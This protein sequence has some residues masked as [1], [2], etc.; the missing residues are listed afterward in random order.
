VINFQLEE[1]VYP[2]VCRYALAQLLLA[3]WSSPDCATE[4]LIKGIWNKHDR[5]SWKGCTHFPYVCGERE[6]AVFCVASIKRM[7]LDSFLKIYFSSTDDDSLVPKLQKIKPS[8]PVLICSSFKEK[9]LSKHDTFQL[10]SCEEIEGPKYMFL[11]KRLWISQEWSPSVNG[12]PDSAFCDHRVIAETVEYI[13]YADCP[14]DEK[15]HKYS[16][17]KYWAKLKTENPFLLHQW[18]TKVFGAILQISVSHIRSSLF[19]DKYDFVGEFI[20]KY[21]NGDPWI[22]YD[23][24]ARRK[25][26][27]KAFEELKYYIDRILADREKERGAQNA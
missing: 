16:I 11:P 9:K 7:Q 22:P 12:I 14:F 21:M 2:E 6:Y 3:E 20:D 8:I 18:D 10:F 4:R 23:M 17:N 25:K 19:S 13:E 26:F 5:S 27:P 1:W 15:I 24:D